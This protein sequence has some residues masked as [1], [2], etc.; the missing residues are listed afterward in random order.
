MNILKRMHTYTDSTVVADALVL[1]HQTVST[2]SADQIW[3][4]FDQF[5]RR[6][7]HL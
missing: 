1:K 2:H 5:Q 4:P 6:I 3:I 7:L